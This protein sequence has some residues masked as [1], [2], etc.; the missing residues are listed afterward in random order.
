MKGVTEYGIFL[1][2]ITVQKF[3]QFEILITVLLK[4][5]I[6]VCRVQGLNSHLLHG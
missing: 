2:W 6:P 1:A 5:K 4:I 3:E